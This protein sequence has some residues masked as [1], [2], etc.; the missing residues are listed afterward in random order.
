MEDTKLTTKQRKLLQIGV[1]LLL[2]LFM[3]TFF[4][5][6]NRKQEEQP[7]PKIKNPTVYLQDSKLQ[8]FDDIYD[9]SDYSDKV[10]VHYPYLLVTKPKLQTTYIYNL[11]EKRKVKEVKEILLDYFDNNQLSTK[12]KTTFYNNTDLGIVCEKGFI[13]DTDTVYCIT[14][15]SRDGVP[16]MLTMINLKTNKNAGMQTSLTGIYTDLKII[17]GKMYLGEIDTNTN[18]SRILVDKQPIDV[19]NIVSF[20][21][22]MKQKPYFASFKSELNKN[23]ES[24]YLIDHGAA[25]KQEDNKIYFFK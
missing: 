13:K 3:G 20:I 1:V 19:P 4:L 8:V 2:I 12:G 21:Y 18:K 10:S 7:T 15:L 5:F 25:I 24:Y 6:Q 23:T 11:D 14:K 17:N 9:F 22:E 16:N